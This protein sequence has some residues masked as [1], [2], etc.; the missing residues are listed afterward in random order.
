MIF[1]LYRLCWIC[2][3][4]EFMLPSSSPAFFG[5][6][7]TFFRWGAFI[8][9]SMRNRGF[10]SDLQVTFHPPDANTTGH[11]F[12]W[13]VPGPD[14]E[15]YG[16]NLA[17]KIM[18]AFDHAW[19]VK[20]EKA[21]EKLVLPGEILAF[22]KQLKEAKGSS[23]MGAFLSKFK[24][25]PKSKMIIG[26]VAGV[27]ANLVEGIRLLGGLSLEAIENYSADVGK[28]V[29]GWADASKLAL[30]LITRQRVFPV[31]EPARSS[32]GTG[33]ISEDE[34]SWR[35]YLATDQDQVRLDN[36]CAHIPFAAR[37]IPLPTNGKNG[38]PVIW[39]E[40]PL[41]ERFLN[42]AA[43][44]IIYDQVDSREM[45]KQTRAEETPETRAE[46]SSVPRRGV[47]KHPEHDKYRE[48]VIPWDERLVQ[49]LLVPE[50][51]FSHIH[52]GDRAVSST[53]WKWI[54]PLTQAAQFPG[55]RVG[56]ALDLPKGDPDAWTV[57]F[58][59]RSVKDPA[60]LVNAAEVWKTQ[61]GHIDAGEITFDR[62]REALVV[63]LGIL[64]ELFPP[65]RPALLEA[66][67]TNATVTFAEACFF[68]KDVAPELSQYG[69]EAI[70][71]ST[72]APGGNNEVSVQLSLVDPPEDAVMRGF[73]IFSLTDYQW[74][75][76]LGDKIL[77]RK[78]F[79]ELMESK[80]PLVQVGEHWI[81]VDPSKSS[82]LQ[83]VASGHAP[84]ALNQMDLV[85][86]ALAGR[87]EVEGVKD[88]I[89]VVLDARISSMME[90]LK[91][92]HASKGE[93]AG[94][95]SS[96][97]LAVQLPESFQ[98]TL[99]PYQERG[100][101]WLHGLSA[102]GFG[103]CLADDMGLG[104]TI[105]V[106]AL[107]LSRAV[108]DQ[109]DSPCS[110][111]QMA[112]LVVCPTSV[113]WNWDAEFQKFAPMLEVGFYYG[114][115][116]PKTPAQLAKL[117]SQH[118]ILL[119]TY[120][121]ATRDAKLLQSVE[122][123][124]VIIDEAQNIKNPETQQAQAIKSVE[125]R[126]RIAL[127]GTPIENRLSELWSIFDFLNPGFLG[128]LSD[129][130]KKFAN[131]IER[132]RDPDALGQLKRLVDPFILRRTKTDKTIISDLPEKEESTM[133]TPLTPEQAA[134]Y[135]SAVTETMAKI[136]AAEGIQRRG[137]I[138]SLLTK[139]KQICNHPVQATGEIEALGDLPLDTLI[140]RSGKVQRLIE[141]C[142]EIVAT[143]DKA[144]IFTQ[145]TQTAQL[146]VKTLSEHFGKQVLYLHGG[147][148]GEKRSTLVDRF[149]DDPDYEVPLFVISLRAGGTG[150]NL[151]AASYVIHFDRWWNPAVEDQA[152]DRAYR[153][154]QE[155][156]VQVFKYTTRG[157]VE[158]R[159]DA[160]IEQKKDLAH[161]I[162][163]SGEQF[164]TELSMDDLKGLFSLQS[165]ALEENEAGGA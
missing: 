28:S 128:K 99:R 5:C 6:L 2:S 138:L 102:W 41:V 24:A 22:G 77:S 50:V 51:P 157:T 7:P 54:A 34:A 59:L 29:L 31:L 18:V 137:L 62:P 45:E 108:G 4:L 151:T 74:E 160:M 141:M 82:L 60:I 32:V 101:Q 90:T 162:V 38:L 155:E 30:E 80:E 129:F 63:G 88:P 112:V 20:F 106:I 159:I 122:W 10:S 105:Q 17:Q 48:I 118:H 152:T 13:F 124:A 68:L 43:K 40:K 14:T 23:Q 146:L 72:M 133:Y 147:V 15:N 132:F 119:T 126:Y 70:L 12:F 164:I 11:F 97:D 123:D 27:K 21:K 139:L 110:P 93:T 135:Q 71:P 19:A 76:S 104:K 53:M 65:I 136:E 83:D 142:E 69:L 143:R 100:V 98:G 96:L 61:N 114:T 161:A 8:L 120:G 116:R 81:F 44:Q 84:K 52:Y 42:A 46:L 153:I 163:T 107:L 1:F 113:L 78:E 3:F 109:D 121:T 89:K 36:I 47:P 26:L 56:F 111:D 92:L 150:L 148:P 58:L 91:A 49:A 67:P 66:S 165:S 130:R 73:D 103:T 134:L 64:S 94:E 158:E 75:V 144:L 156:N 9:D 37:A 87:V 145:Y 149:Q 25:L 117:V 55:F 16:L 57:R 131:P 85:H 125:G 79:E 86:A 33:G 35:L 39:R 140:K 115:D 154:G 95:I 127:T